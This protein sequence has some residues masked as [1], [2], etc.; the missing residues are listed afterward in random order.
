MAT[1][2]FNVRDEVKAAFN[3]TFVKKNKS[4]IIAQ[5][6]RDADEERQRQQRRAPAIDALLKLRKKWKSQSQTLRKYITV[7][8]N[9]PSNSNTTS[10]IRC[11]MRLHSAQPKLCS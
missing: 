5:I 2:N 8:V 1:V 11:I 7:R 4:T 6:M 9:W 10:S 3:N